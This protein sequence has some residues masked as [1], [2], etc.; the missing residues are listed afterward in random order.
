[1]NKPEP[2]SPLRY[3]KQDFLSS[4]VVFFV[5]L[6][7]CMGV[8]LAS[9]APV[10]AGLITGIVGGIVAGSLAGCQLQV[11]GPAAGLTVIVFE[12]IQRLG[13]EMLGLAVLIAGAM[14]IVAGGL[15]L[16]PWFRAVSPAVIHGM[17]AGI[18][19][20]IF[21][22]Q[23]HVMV[24]DKPRRS[25]LENLATIPQAIYK[26]FNGPPL[27][28]EEERIFRRHALQEMADLHHDQIN[29]RVHAAEL[30]PYAHIAPASPALEQVEEPQLKTLIPEQERIT[31]HLLQLR[32]EMITAEGASDGQV[33]LDAAKV[34]LQEAIVRSEAAEAAL[35]S[36]KAVDAIATQE[37]AVA[38][39][40]VAAKRLRNH[41]IAAILGIG[42]IVIIILWQKLSPRK[43]R[44][45]PAPLIA[46]VAALL[47]AYFLMLPVFYV[48]LPGSLWEEVRLPTLTLL[49]NAHWGELLQTAALIAIIASAE[50][51]LCATAVDQLAH[52]QRT[53][54]DREL[55]AQGVGNIICGT[56]GALPM[57][58]VI[59][60]SSANV[61]AGAKSRLSTIL[62]GVWL[63]VFVV[64]LGGLL[65]M[66]PT[67][68]L[69]AVLV[70]TGYKLVNIKEIK[71]LL[72][73]G[74]G[75]VAIYLAT[76][77]TIVAKDLLVGVVVGIALAAAK[78]LYTFSRLGIKIDRDEAQNRYRMRLAGAAT[79]VRLPKLAAALEQFPSDAEVQVELDRL[80]YIDHAC[81]ELLTSWGEQHQA[82]GGRLSID[83]D[84]LRASAHRSSP[85]RRTTGEPEAA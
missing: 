63:L 11:S 59:V 57:T 38:A 67:A 80:S 61:Q 6:P 39:I 75:E 7:L 3:W 71:R 36:G 14:Q 15:K 34:A 1:M 74:W 64:A 17:L 26:T 28:G 73:F 10:A 85:R 47:A 81:L 84:T 29:M 48:E 66:I 44:L 69:A 16:G 50:T 51:L 18:G 52:G 40:D 19:V 82:S 42:T 25:G 45:V 83:W 56:L 68:S 23:F 62:H 49:Q 33:H 46:I 76:L 24:D 9:G 43:L 13:L 58:G 31:R 5:A 20:L 8:A 27:A 54:Y 72:E 60:R 4:I 77:I 53:N 30:I 12:I 79:F 65:Q 78:L 22:S 37:A 55:T 21:A 41:R 2:A 32:D 35:R 70:Y